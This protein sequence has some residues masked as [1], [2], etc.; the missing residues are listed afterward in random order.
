MVPPTSG[1]VSPVIATG[2]QPADGCTDQPTYSVNRPCHL[3][4]FH[5]APDRRGGDAATLRNS[6]G[7]QWTAI[8]T[9]QPAEDVPTLTVG[10]EHMVQSS[11]REKSG[12]HVRRPNIRAYIERAIT[13]GR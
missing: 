12:V 13:D 4:R 5:A 6:G 9:R 7:E 1:E 11:V 8:R 3:K 2:R 10:P